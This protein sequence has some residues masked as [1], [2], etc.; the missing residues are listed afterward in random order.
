LIVVGGPTETHRI[1][2]PVAQFFDRIGT[3][4]LVGTAAAAFDTRL[5]W[6]RGSPPQP[7]REIAQK[8]QRARVNVIAPPMSVFVSGKVPVL[9]RGEI[10]RASAWAVSLAAKLVSIS[11][12]RTAEP[13]RA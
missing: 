10:E 9:E 12:T 5:R 8:V 3:G 13:I 2:E 1:T 7:L 4:E 11:V 6:S